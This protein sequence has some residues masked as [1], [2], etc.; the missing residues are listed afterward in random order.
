M[1]FVHGVF[2]KTFI[3]PASAVI[4]NFSHYNFIVQFAWIIPLHLHI[5]IWYIVKQLCITHH[6]LQ[7]IF[8]NYIL[9]AI[10]PF[11]FQTLFCTNFCFLLVLLSKSH[12]YL[13]SFQL[14]I[15]TFFCFYSFFNYLEWLDFLFFPIFS[16]KIHETLNYLQVLFWSH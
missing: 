4:Y 12:L 1:C 15:L 16:N 13:S 14:S 3:F 7:N 9:I 6:N 10:D 2:L 8:N 11:S 5:S